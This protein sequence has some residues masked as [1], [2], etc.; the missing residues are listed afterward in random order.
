MIN[1]NMCKIEV[2]NFIQKFC[3]IG[4]YSKPDIPIKSKKLKLIY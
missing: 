4:N 3:L 2:R 1:L